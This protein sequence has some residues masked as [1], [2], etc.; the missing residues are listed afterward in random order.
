VI[1]NAYGG[2]GGANAADY[3]H[4]GSLIVATGGGSGFY[5]KRDYE[6]SEFPTVVAVGGTTLTQGGSGRG[7]SEKVYDRTGSGCSKFA[8]PAWQNDKGCKHRTANDVAAVADPST[9]VAIY[10]SYSYGGWE[11][12]GGGSVASDIITGVYGLAGNASQL[13]AAQSLYAPGSQAYLN[14]VTT[15]IDG[16]CKPAYLCSGEVGYDGPTGMGTPNGIGAF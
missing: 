15:G 8:K 4:P 7:W 12:F 16:I 9:G 14:D 11:I 2:N 6:P 10:N 3:D 1:G 13:T 5:T